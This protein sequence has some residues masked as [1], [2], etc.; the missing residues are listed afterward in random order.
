MGSRLMGS[1]SLW[2]HSAFGIIQ[3]MGSFSLCDQFFLGIQGLLVQSVKQSVRR[4]L[5][6]FG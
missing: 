2:D 6:S 5:V 4:L 3:L 1:F